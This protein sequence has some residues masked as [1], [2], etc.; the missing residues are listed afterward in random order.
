MKK[1]C[2]YVP[3]S[4]LEDTKA[5]L[6]GA[7]AGRIGAYAECCWQVEGS[8]QFR[9]LAGSSPYLGS[10]GELESV[11]EYRVEML[12]APEHL[13]AAL[14]ALRNAHPYEEPAWDVTDVLAPGDGAG[15]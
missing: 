7:G 3:A 14:A 13:A 12:C 4:H 8:G 15:V 6:F 11:A 1:L 2:Y 10:A 5:A 9:P